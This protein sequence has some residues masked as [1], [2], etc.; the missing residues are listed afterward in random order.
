MTSTTDNNKSFA[1]FASDFSKEH[2]DYLNKWNEGA[3]PIKKKVA[4]IIIE[5]GGFPNDH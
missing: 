5:A 1:I 3:D 4:K 2:A